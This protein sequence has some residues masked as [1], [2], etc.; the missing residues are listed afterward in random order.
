[1]DQA[2]IC[3]QSNQQ[4]Q[5]FGFEK[6]AKV[7]TLLEIIDRMREDARPADNSQPG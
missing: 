5:R 3:E 1:M 6:V 7:E 2:R 4:L